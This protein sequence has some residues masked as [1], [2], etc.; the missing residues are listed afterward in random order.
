MKIS[1]PRKRTTLCF[2]AVASLPCLHAQDQPEETLE[3]P[4]LPEIIGLTI[5]GEAHEHLANIEEFIES[6][7][8]MISMADPD[9]IYDPLG[10]VKDG[11]IE[12]PEEVAVTPP[13]NPDDKGPSNPV[14]PA[15]DMLKT[16]VDALEITGF[17]SG[18]GSILLG[19]REITIGQLVPG[20]NDIF[21]SDVKPHQ[22]SF[23]STASGK[24]YS[25]PVGFRPSG[26]KSR[27]DNDFLNSIEGVNRR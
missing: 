24:E 1:L 27:N 13:S 3:T 21:L 10:I 25:R 23:K 18:G 4:K 14:A 7:F 19:V 22:V 26:V 6:R 11:E 9:R 12:P 15:A 17:N 16:T 8:T 5:Q 2:L 20:S